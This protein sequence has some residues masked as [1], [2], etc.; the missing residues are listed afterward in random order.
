MTIIPSGI[1]QMWVIA[2]LQMLSRHQDEARA[3]RMLTVEMVK[4]PQ[5]N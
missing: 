3:A 2:L 1:E 5:Q 4:Q